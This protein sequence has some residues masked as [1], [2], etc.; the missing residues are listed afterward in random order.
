[1]KKIIDGKIYDTEKAEVIFFF[2]PEIYG[3]DYVA[4]GPCTR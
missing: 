3:S 4:E 1:M 2:S